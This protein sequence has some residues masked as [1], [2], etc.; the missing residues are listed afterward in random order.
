[1]S[2]TAGVG[3][4]I[5]G[6]GIFSYGSNPTIR[7]IPENGYSFVEW[8]GEG[9]ENPLSSVTTVSMFEEREISARF[10]ANQFNLSI[11]SGSGGT[12]QGEGRYPYGSYATISATPNTGF[13][14]VRWE[15][16]GI[17]DKN[18]STSTVLMTE[19]HSITAFFTEESYNLNLIS[20]L[21]GTVRGEE[22]IPMDQSSPSM[23][24]PKRASFLMVGLEKE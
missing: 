18:Q 16:N 19:N 7:A 17:T 20:G 3:G 4:S 12:V 23:Q 5:E 11:I 6:E 13:S 9:L 21:G 15:G 22:N 24:T 10:V 14:F 8:I 1:M 2:V